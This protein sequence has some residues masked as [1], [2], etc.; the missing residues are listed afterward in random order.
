M[1][2]RNSTM[3]DLVNYMPTSTVWSCANDINNAG[4]IVGSLSCSEGGFAF[5]LDADYNLT[6]IAPG[7]ATAINNSGQII[8]RVGYNNSK[9]W[10]YENGSLT[11]LNDLID[12]ASGWD[13]ARVYDIN[14]AGQIVGYGSRGNS[15]YQSHRAFLLNPIPEPLTFSLLAAGSIISLRKRKTINT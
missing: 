1:L 7:T 12:P 2:Y 9:T 4:T 15:S 8:G 3:I 14:D 6:L 11:Y 5:T 10:I 13:L